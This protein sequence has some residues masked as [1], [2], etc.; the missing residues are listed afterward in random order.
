MSRIAYAPGHVR[1]RGAVDT[2]STNGPSVRFG[3][4]PVQYVAL[5]VYFEAIE[6]LQVSHFSS[7]RESWRSEYPE[8][9]ELPPLRPRN[10][11]GEETAVV[12]I[13]QAWP[14]P[15]LMFSTADDVETIAI[16]SDR[17]TKTWTFSPGA[18]EYP[19][20]DALSHDMEA[21]F[22]QFLEAVNKE[23]GQ[24]VQP[25][26]SECLYRNSIDGWSAE[27]LMVGIA[28]RWEVQVVKPPASLNAAYAGVRLHTRSDKD[29]PGCA[30]TLSL[31][32]DEDG[33]VLTLESDYMPSDEIEL[34]GRLGGIDVAHDNLIRKFVEFTNPEMH[35][36]W[37]KLT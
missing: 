32:V 20:F 21:R 14:F 27:E 9:A 17:F 18:N 4:P 5:T 3:R 6:G 25:F 35:A 36:K 10:R 37:G 28:T 26:A 16:Q 12:P 24:T 33:S 31:D 30:V 34:H 29:I 22:G 1:Y 13:A 15:Y 7:L 19:G 11:G 23:T 2:H 8:T